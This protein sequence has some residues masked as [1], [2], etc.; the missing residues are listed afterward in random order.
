MK[1][2]SYT[3]GKATAENAAICGKLNTTATGSN[4]GLRVKVE[5]DGTASAEASKLQN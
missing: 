1:G 3:Y 4:T 5:T 2:Y